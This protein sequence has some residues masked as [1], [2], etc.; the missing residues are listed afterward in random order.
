MRLLFFLF[1][2]G[3]QGV[4]Q[5]QT[6]T[7]QALEALSIKNYP[8]LKQANILNNTAELNIDNIKKALYPQVSVNG[9]ATY[10]SDVTSI[11]IPIAGFSP[12]PLSKDQYR[13][14]VDIQ[15]NIYDGGLNKKMQDVVIA[16]SK[17]ELLKNEVDIYKLRERVTQIYCSIL[18]T[19]EVVKQ[20]DIINQDLNNALQ[21]VEA[22]LNNG[23]VFKNNVLQI[24]AQLLKNGQKKEE[25]LAA[26]RTLLDAMALLANISISDKAIFELPVV[27]FDEMKSTAS[28]RPE[29]LLFD[30]QKNSIE[31]QLALVD[32]KTNPKLGAFVQTGFGRPALNMLNN[33]F[34]WF[35]IGG[36]KLQWSLGGYYTAK[37]E[38]TILTNQVKLVQNEKETYEL[39]NNIQ[40]KQQLD[41]INKLE[42][43]L[44][45]D[46]QI[47]EIREQIKNTSLVQLN[48]GVIT[49]N[50]YL[51]EISE[52]DLANQAFVQHQTQLIQ[53]KLQYQ[54]I[55]GKN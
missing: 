22:L 37:K 18:Y 52:F 25:A 1:I 26:K 36:L 48:N 53:S 27:Q 3:M 45:T 29:I 32:V 9:Q 15:Q 10:Q 21:K 31:T 7:I 11:N 43:L 34:S 6:Y 42:K 54:L 4:S 2:V 50:D 17:V 47:I 30:A 51:K 16:G 5:A 33:D 20:I 14:T 12:N 41:E 55:K 46:K 35:G 38:K 13:A 19:N 28:I 44:T 40:L 39:N 23:L 24:K 8:L 49:A